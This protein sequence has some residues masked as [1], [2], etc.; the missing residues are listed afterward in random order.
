MALFVMPVLHIIKC[1]QILK[2]KRFG[3]E[4]G[5]AILL[6]NF[7]AACGGGKKRMA[8]TFGSR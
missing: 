8:R 5:G 6:I 7:Y 1:I 4:D 3:T 2:Q